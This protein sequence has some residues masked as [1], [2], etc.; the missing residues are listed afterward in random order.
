MDRRGYYRFLKSGGY[1]EEADLVALIK[2]HQFEMNYACGYRNMYRWLRNEKGI[3]IGA[4]RIL[5]AMRRMNMLSCVRR[6]KYTPEQY[7]I[8]KELLKNV[9]E[10]ILNRDFHADRPG[11]KY[12][13]DITYLHGIG[14]TKYLA[15]IEDLYNGEIV[16]W[17]I[18]LH[19]DLT[20]CTECVNMLAARRDV[21]GALLHSD[22]GSSYL[23]LDYRFTLKELGI[24][25]SCSRKG[26]CWDNA[27][28]ESF[29]G[30]LKSEA[31]Y[32]RFKKTA[33]RNHRIPIEHIE[34]AVMDFID[35]YNNIRPKPRLGGKSPASFRKESFPEFD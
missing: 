34:R 28:M 3:F 6:R 10:N 7:K 11:Q 16:A 14:V 15:T 1:E 25:Q 31:L 18:G 9:P 23:A 13:S 33:V 26:Q 2:E 12:V 4:N 30:V 27:P 22:E 35:Y 5:A 17:K 24:I 21:R 8:R 19:P 29:N 20:L 32:C